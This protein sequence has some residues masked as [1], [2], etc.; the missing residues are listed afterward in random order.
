[1][2]ACRL[3]IPV[4]SRWIIPLMSCCI[5]GRTRSLITF[6]INRNPFLPQI[7]ILVVRLRFLLLSQFIS[8]FTSYVFSHLIPHIS[9]FTSAFQFTLIFHCAFLKVVQYFPDGITINLQPVWIFSD[10]VWTAS[11]KCRQVSPMIGGGERMACSMWRR[12][13]RPAALLLTVPLLGLV[14]LILPHHHIRQITT[15]WGLIV[16]GWRIHDYLNCPLEG[17]GPFSARVLVILDC[18]SITCSH[19]WASASRKLTPASA[20]RHP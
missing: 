9:H 20:F 3:Y 17:G 5:N 7:Y 6:F 2:K 4:K 10:L 1:M 14:L 18:A 12:L 15:R 8:R 13:A 11:L 19:S 16:T